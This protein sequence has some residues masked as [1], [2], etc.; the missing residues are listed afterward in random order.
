MLHQKTMVVDGIWVTVGT[1][2][3][4]NRSFALDEESNVC[5]YDNALAQQLEEIFMEDLKSCERVRLDK[6]RHRGLRKR[7]FGATCVFLKEQI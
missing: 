6:W 7:V 4:D 3:F 2:N 1:T 5:V